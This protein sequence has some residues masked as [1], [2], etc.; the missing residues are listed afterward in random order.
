M[1][2]IDWMNVFNLIDD[3]ECKLWLDPYISK[4]IFAEHDYEYD[5]VFEGELFQIPIVYGNFYM[6]LNESNIQ[7][8][9]LN[10]YI[11][12]RKGE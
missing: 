7:D 1:K 6:V 3:L 8:G 12:E 2:L 10:I 11:R 5:I 4:E 9:I